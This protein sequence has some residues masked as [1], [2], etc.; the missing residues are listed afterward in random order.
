M[1][2][3]RSD[4]VAF[5]IFVITILALFMTTIVMFSGCSAIDNV[6]MANKS[7]CKA[8]SSCVCEPCLDR[9]IDLTEELR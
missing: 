9:Q 6:S 1:N 4:K 8:S 2:N 3:P 7:G 5:A